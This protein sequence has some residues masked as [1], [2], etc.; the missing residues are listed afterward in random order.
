[1]LPVTGCDPGTEAAPNSGAWV[2]DKLAGWG[3]AAAPA[4]TVLGG[5]ETATLPSPAAGATRPGM[6]AWP[7]VTDTA[8]GSTFAGEATGGG[9]ALVPPGVA[10]ALPSSCPLLTKPVTPCSPSGP[11]YWCALTDRFGSESP[12]IV[13]STPPEYLVTTS[14]WP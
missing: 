11:S 6:A 4:V 1:M 5:S 7:T 8:A 3:G 14:T 2:A 12:P 13:S 10:V 9:A